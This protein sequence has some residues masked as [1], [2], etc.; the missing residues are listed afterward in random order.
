MS[1]AR[2]GSVLTIPVVIYVVH[3]QSDP[4]GSVDHPDDMRI[5]QGID[6]INEVLA[7]QIACGINQMGEDVGIRLCLASR[8]IRG[9]SSSGIVHIASS[10]ATMDACTQELALKNLPKLI[11]DN[12]PN[13][14]YLNIYLVKDIC[15]SCI[16]GGCEVGGF[17]A[18][19]STHGTDLDGMVLESRNWMNANC[20]LNKVIVHEL[21]HYLNL[22]H[23]WTGGCKNDHCLVD[24][25]KVCDTPPDQDQNSYPDHPCLKGQD[26]NSCTT[27]V[28]PGDPN[29]PFSVDQMDLRSNFMDYIP[30]GCMQQFTAG[31]ILRMQSTLQFARKSL[32]ESRGC[33]PPCNP[34]INLN[35]VYPDT[36]FIGQSYILNNTSSGADSYIWKYEGSEINSADLVINPLASGTAQIT[37]LGYSNQQGCDDSI[38]ISI[39]IVCGIPVP[40][41]Q[42]AQGPGAR[43]YIFTLA[44]YATGIIQWLI[45]G[46]ALGQADTLFWTAPVEGDYS[47][48]ASVCDQVCCSYAEPVYLHLGNCPSPLAANNWI[49]G[50]DEVYVDFNSGTPVEIPIPNGPFI[51]D[52]GV[53]I[54]NDP[55]T[56]QLLFYTDGAYLYDKNHVQVIGSFFGFFSSSS[57]QK[58]TLLKPGQDSIWYIFLPDAFRSS[59]PKNDSLSELHVITINM[60]LNNGLGN[61]I[62]KTRVLL[63]PVTEKV[64]AVRHC[65]GV[66]WWILSLE[67]GSNKLHA[68]LLDS[69]GIHEP[70]VVSTMNQTSGFF[71]GKAGQL[72][73]SSNQLL[74]AAA[75]RYENSDT[76]GI[77]ELSKFDPTSGLIEYIGTID[78]IRTPYGVAFSPSEKFLYFS[79]L[80][81]WQNTQQ[82]VYQIPVDKIFGH[83]ALSTAT[84][85]SSDK[86]SGELQLGPDRKLY[87]SRIETNYISVIKDPDL[88]FPLCDYVQKGVV[89][90][91]GES[92]LGLPCYPTGIMDPGTAFIKGPEELC[93]SVSSQ[94]YTAYSRCGYQEYSWQHL[95]S[96]SMERISQDSVLFRPGM[97][98]VDTLIAH[99]QSACTSKPDTLF[100]QVSDCAL[101]CIPDFEW[102]EADTVVCAGESAWLRWSSTGRITHIQNLNPA[103]PAFQ[104]G[105]YIRIPEPSQS[106]SFRIDV[107]YSPGCDTTIYVQVQVDTAQSLSFISYDSIACSGA[108]LAIDF[109]SSASL[110]QWLNPATGSILTNPALP[111]QVGPLLADSTYILKLSSPER[112]CESILEL[113][114][115]LLGQPVHLRDSITICRGDSVFVTGSWFFGPTEVVDSFQTSRGCDSIHTTIV[116]LNPSPE[117]AYSVEL[118]CPSSAQNILGSIQLSGA[119]SDTWHIFWSNDPQDSTWFEGATGDYEVQV[120]NAFGCD[121]LLNINI[122]EYPVPQLQYITGDASCLGRSDASI[123]IQSLQNIELLLSGPILDTINGNPILLED[124]PAGNYQLNIRDENGCIFDQSLSLGSGPAAGILSDTILLCAYDSILIHEVFYRAPAIIHDTIS[125]VDAC[126]SIYAYHLI[127]K[128]N[129]DP[130]YHLLP[131]CPANQLGQLVFNQSTG[132]LMLMVDEIPTAVSDTLSLSTGPHILL[133]QLPGGCSLRDSI[134]I[135][136]T[137]APDPDISIL[138]E[139]CLDQSDGQ[140]GLA[141]EQPLT[142]HLNNLPVQE[143]NT[144]T[145]TDLSPGNYALSYMDSSGCYYDTTLIVKSGTA[146][147]ISDQ[148]TLLIKS[149]SCITLSPLIEPGNDLVHIQWIA[150][151]PVDCDTCA[152]TIW[153][154]GNA[155][156]IQVMVENA[157]GCTDVHTYQVLRIPKGTIFI[158]NG[159][160]PNDDGV[161]DTWSLLGDTEGL[162]SARIYVFERWGGTVFTSDSPQFQ[163]DG[164]LKGKPLLSGVYIFLLQLEYQTGLRE[165]K[166]GD[167]T[168]WR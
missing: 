12:Y 8:T 61:V 15:A 16:P 68:W 115:R 27:D 75:I 166:T 86:H 128:P 168:I 64:T 36:M 23:T 55:L 29:N 72:V 51:A 62:N 143:G 60:K 24:G 139:S 97:V 33:L 127:Q 162:R 79:S 99:R 144:A 26:I 133:W 123:V 112:G 119:N 154:S 21:G 88:P 118:A 134:F 87:I 71:E 32:L 137:L 78:S 117:V 153:C 82:G 9:D 93:D 145:W 65:N 155:E 41:I 116:L 84:L 34:K 113:P 48:R 22:Y 54:A 152:S 37:L 157:A 165:E 59:D 63:K 129:P 47:I 91:S 105:S 57:T 126:D 13:T 156:S 131:A 76:F 163:W 19:A 18:Y 11:E 150:N 4:M 95:G 114:F 110:V 17:A 146:I 5:Q 120:K 20:D 14:D 109:V 77:I 1:I 30:P 56:G 70:S 6:Y 96:G 74:T 45:N 141:N 164:K 121:T 142:Y 2:K 89:F 38:S 40:V 42:Q 101:Q 28:N 138:D 149:D 125:Q 102:V 83:I 81:S 39:P 3:D 107:H 167:V 52:E 90:Q 10:L 53:A 58:L 100:I 46:Q 111:I 104:E 7:G 147:S 122:P 66:D 132:N 124:L 136:S 103:V 158:P 135:S 69:S 98:G 43:D 130:S 67:A 106:A 92:F 25:D 31:Q 50:R 140:I 161:N 94:I 44:N 151:P 85:I 80:P 148:D 108:V 49:F 35:S 159:F 73:A 160:S